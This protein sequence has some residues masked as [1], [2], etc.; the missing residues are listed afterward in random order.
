MLQHYPWTT[1]T[2]LVCCPCRCNSWYPSNRDVG[3]SAC[4]WG[5]QLDHKASSEGGTTCRYDG[6]TLLPWHLVFW[7]YNLDYLG[8]G[9]GFPSSHSQYMGYFSS[10]LIMHLFFRHRFTSSRNKL[11]DI[12]F[13]LLVYV[14]LV[15]LALV[16]C[17]SRWFVH[18]GSNPILP[19]YLYST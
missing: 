7:R 16:V 8:S 5:T 3:W 14:I 13:R 15:S 19:Q 9:Y 2:G 4:L 18:L 1:C 11:L 6:V 17:Y 12:M 10:F